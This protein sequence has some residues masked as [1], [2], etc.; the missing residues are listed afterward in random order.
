MTYKGHVH[1]G[2][3]VLDDPTQL[4]EGIRVEITVVRIL[5]EYESKTPLRGTPYKFD[6]PF[7]PALPESEWESVG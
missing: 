3:V 6:D 5:P 2:V 4:E 1:N 7:S